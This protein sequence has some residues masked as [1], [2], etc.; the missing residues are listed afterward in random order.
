M[1]GS[2]TEKPDIEATLV[3][4]E[5]EDPPI[6]DLRAAPR[7]SPLSALLST[8]AWGQLAVE[9][10]EN[11]PQ[12]QWPMSNWTYHA[13]RNDSHIDSLLSGII[14]PALRMRWSLNANGADDNIVE[15]ISKD[16]NIPIQ[17]TPGDEYDENWDGFDFGAHLYHVLLALAYGHMYFD[18][19]GT[20]QEDGLWHIEE[21]DP[22]M[23]QTIM[24]INIDA[25]GKLESI[26]QTTSGL[27]SVMDPP[28]LTADRIVPYVWGK[29][30][31]NWVGRSMFR[32][33]YRDWLIK[34]RVLRVGAINIERAGAGV[35]I[36]EAPPGATPAQI[37]ALDAMAQAFKVGE[38][39]GGAVPNGAKLRLMGVEGTQPDAIKYVNYLD[40][41][42]ARSFLA[43]LVQLGQT[44]TGSRALGM[45]FSELM[46]VALQAVADWF[47]NYFNRIVIRRDVRWNY[48]PDI[49]QPRLVYES[50]DDPNLAVADL[51]SL[52]DTGAVR[53]DAELLTWVRK[54]YRLP[55]EL[56][57]AGAPGPVPP[58]PPTPTPEENP[59]A[60]G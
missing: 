8:S 3:E 11:A 60:G 59:V 53:I 26:R 17:G 12:L 55:Q 49:K 52:I 21:M 42:M 56:E 50:F 36:V 16:Y 40:E 43:M 48:G 25:R 58:P 30:G 28:P 37:A 2:V 19:W 15:K 41:S 32:P 1:G 39:A 45:T 29:E 10:M 44:K 4:K 22:I 7:S 34:D 9:M 38:D 54:K 33:L 18:E 35:P 5:S 51:V 6:R 31:S 13:M 47:V 20:I 14:M 23:P 57:D 24:E 27:G 46:N